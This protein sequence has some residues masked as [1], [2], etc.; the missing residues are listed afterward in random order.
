MAFRTKEVDGAHMLVVHAMQ[1]NPKPEVCD[2]HVGV[3]EPEPPLSRV[4]GA[5]SLELSDTQVC[6]P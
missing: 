2:L 5:A 3:Y 1:V 6:E 4:H